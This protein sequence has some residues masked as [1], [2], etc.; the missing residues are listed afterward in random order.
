MRPQAAP[1]AATRSVS[2]MQGGGG[3]GFAHREAVVRATQSRVWG[4]AVSAPKNGVPTQLAHIRPRPWTAHTLGSCLELQGGVLSGTPRPSGGA[5]DS[6]S[7]GSAPGPSASIPA[8]SSSFQTTV[9]PHLSSGAT[10]STEPR[11]TL[12]AWLQDRCPWDR[13]TEVSSA[14][15][16]TCQGLLVV[17]AHGDE[18]PQAG[19]ELLHDG[20]GESREHLNDGWR[21]LPG[22]RGHAQLCP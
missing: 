10:D 11:P 1:E 7:A 21:P 18:V 19:V 6:Y 17:L 8:L 12:S 9:T 3:G 14:P 15:R 22:A 16:L 20:L 5:A 2:E 4:P 13:G